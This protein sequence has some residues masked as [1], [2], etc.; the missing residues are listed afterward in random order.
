MCLGLF[1]TSIPI[2]LFF[3]SFISVIDTR[4]G[5]F[6]IVIAAEVFVNG[7]GSLLHSW[8]QFVF[9]VSW[10]YYFTIRVDEHGDGKEEYIFKCFDFEY[11]LSDQV[12]PKTKRKPF[13]GYCGFSQQSKRILWT[14]RAGS[15]GF[16][17][18]K[19]WVLVRALSQQTLI[20]KLITSTSRAI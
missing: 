4:M 15:R 10:L 12:P 6:N 18:L 3:N 5:D 17:G 2:H 13:G 20:C 14:L 7:G 9:A 1:L 8:C 11:P 16:Q 19:K